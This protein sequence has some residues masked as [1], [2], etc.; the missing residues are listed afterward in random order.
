MKSLIVVTG[1]EKEIM[2]TW[3]S[4]LRSKGVYQGDALICDYG[5]FSP[6]TVNYLQSQKNIIYRKVSKVHEC[7]ASDRIRAFYE[8]L[9]DLWEQYDC[10]LLTDGNDIEF[11]ASIEPLLNL[12]RTGLCAVKEPRLIQAYKIWASKLK[13]P[14]RYWRAIEN[15]PAFN[16]GMIAA[17]TVEMKALLGFMLK[18]MNLYGSNFGSETFA[19]NVWCYCFGHEIR[20][21][22]VR[23]NCMPFMGVKLMMVGKVLFDQSIQYESAR[24]TPFSGGGVDIAILHWHKQN[25]ERHFPT[26]IHND[27]RFRYLVSGDFVKFEMPIL[28]KNCEDYD[29]E[30]KRRLKTQAVGRL[31]SFPFFSL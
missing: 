24:L 3:L 6:E 30:I 25:Q 4:S 19:L 12:A 27:E 2:Q 1:T 5:N 20:N 16:A 7:F 8:C 14:L 17:P 28:I 21:V 11:F 9:T 31:N 15:K 18:N 22:G 23:W 13:M 29:P 10:L 26:N